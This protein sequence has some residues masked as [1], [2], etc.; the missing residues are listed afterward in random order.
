MKKI[1]SAAVAT[2]LIF[3]PCANA[4]GS[5]IP[6]KYQE[7]YKQYEGYKSPYLAE[8]ERIMLLSE[9]E[10][11]QEFLDSLT[12]TNCAGDLNDKE[13]REL[14]ESEEYKKASSMNGYFESLIR[15]D[16]Q[17]R[18]EEQNQAI[19]SEYII[20]WESYAGIPSSEMSKEDCALHSY[21][22]IAQNAVGL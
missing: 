18:T 21:Y 13:V 6:E 5:K 22:G 16:D 3:A 4:A 15:A 2:V 11:K 10:R 1:L 20:K 17:D 19:R 12:I 7:I 8:L 9:D 14:L